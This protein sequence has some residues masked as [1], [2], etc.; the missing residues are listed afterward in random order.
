MNVKLSPTDGKDLPNPTLYPQLV[1][2]LNY[3]T[4]TGPDISYVVHVVSQFM[5]SPRTSHFAAV[6]RILRY[7]KGTLYQG[8][9]FSSIS[10]F[11][12]RAYTDSDWDGDIIDRRSTT[13]LLYV[14]RQL[15]YFLEKQETNSCLSF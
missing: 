7:V 2:S 13:G 12:L 15:S 8:L 1:G 9:H 10:D 14:L 6:L 5:A 4:I 3:L 11:P